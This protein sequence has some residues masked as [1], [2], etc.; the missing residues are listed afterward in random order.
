[1]SLILYCNVSVE[2]Y[3]STFL[4][5][6]LPILHVKVH[7][8]RDLILVGRFSRPMYALNRIYTSIIHTDLFLRAVI[9]LVYK[10]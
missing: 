9:I 6:N 2:C 5:N 8:Y 4:Q 3:M 7:S 1:M 10:Q